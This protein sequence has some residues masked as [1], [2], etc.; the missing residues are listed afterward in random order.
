MTFYFLK[1]SQII[2]GTAVEQSIRSVMERLSKGK[3]VGKCKEGSEVIVNITRIFPIILDTKDKKRE[4][5]L[6][7]LGIGEFQEPKL[8]LTPQSGWLHP[9]AHP[10]FPFCKEENDT[11]WKYIHLGSKKMTQFI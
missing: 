11:F 9:L 3:H 1:R 8:K 7:L 10:L 6:D 4:K 5:K 2:L